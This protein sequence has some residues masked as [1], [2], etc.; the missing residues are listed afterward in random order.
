MSYF[1][2]VE[3]GHV[4]D[5]VGRFHPT[6]HKGV[7]V[8][9]KPGMRFRVPIGWRIEI[10]RSSFDADYYKGQGGGWADIGGVRYGIVMAHMAAA[11][12]RGVYKSGELIGKVA[13]NVRFT[14]HIHIALATG[15]IPPPG[16]VDPVKVW[17][18]NLPR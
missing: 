15:H 9:A 5:R 6:K 10:V 8:F 3:N 16:E 14:P 18:S 4:F 13:G 2:G 12:D 7:D 11:P 17:E 1:L